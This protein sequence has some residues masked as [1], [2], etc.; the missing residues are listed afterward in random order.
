M[1]LQRH[2]KL[3][4]ETLASLSFVPPYNEFAINRWTCED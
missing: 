2:A 1:K 3:I 4:V